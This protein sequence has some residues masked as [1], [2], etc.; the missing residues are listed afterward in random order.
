MLPVT[1]SAFFFSYVSSCIIHCSQLYHYKFD[2]IIQAHFTRSS[3]SLHFKSKIVHFC[4]IWLNKLHITG[5]KILSIL[6][7]RIRK[8]PDGV[9]ELL[10]SSLFS[11]EGFFENVIDQSKIDTTL[12]DCA[13]SSVSQV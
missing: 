12:P 7:V 6:T 3:L 5:G 2:R 8:T 4:V 1:L 13:M 9:M 10:G 11:L